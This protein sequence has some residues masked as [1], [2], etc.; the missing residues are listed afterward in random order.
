MVYETFW[1]IQN[2]GFRS[3]EES[4]CVCK[5]IVIRNFIKGYMEH[6]LNSLHTYFFIFLLSAVFFFK[7]NF[8][9]KFFQELLSECQT[10]CIQIRTDILS[11]LIWVQTVCKGYQQMTNIATCKERVKYEGK[12]GI[13]EPHGTG[14]FRANKA[15]IIYSYFVPVCSI[16]KTITPRCCGRPDALLHE[17]E[18]NSASGRPR[19]W[20][21]IVWLYYK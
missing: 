18:C 9:K 6:P 17:A 4:I 15:D 13:L 20:G 7:F 12:T 10:V 16:V 5:Y 21:V 8:F 11:V 3:L 1:A 2:Y 19:Y 14:L